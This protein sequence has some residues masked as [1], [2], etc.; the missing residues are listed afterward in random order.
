L[1]DVILVVENMKKSYRRLVDEMEAKRLI[2]RVSVNGV[3]VWARYYLSK[4][5]I[6][7][8]YYK[9]RGNLCRV[10]EGKELVRLKEINNG[11]PV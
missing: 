2:K 10:L 11:D 8:A 4:K 3:D 7:K 9:Q 1:P 5:A 6:R